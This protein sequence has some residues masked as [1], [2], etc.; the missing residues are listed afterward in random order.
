MRKIA[1][2]MACLGLCFFM[3]ISLQAQVKDKDKDNDKYKTGT[4]RDKDGRDRSNGKALDKEMNERLSNDLYSRN[5][6]AKDEIIVWDNTDDGYDGAYAVGNVKYL[7]HYDSQGKYVETLA[8]RKWDDKVPAKV[9]NSYETSGYRSNKVE[10]F[11]EVNEPNKKGYYL[12]FKDNDGKH[13][14]VWSDENGK[15]SERS[16]NKVD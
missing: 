16:R 2:G 6:A 5:P 9:R 8:E 4:E 13:R 3:S 1:G 7:A 14:R 12:E 15:F 11:W 10:H